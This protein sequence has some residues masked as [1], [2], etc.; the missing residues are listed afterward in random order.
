[1][2][3]KLQVTGEKKKSKKLRYLQFTHTHA[4]PHAQFVTKTVPLYAANY[5]AELKGHRWKGHR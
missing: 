5:T 4:H 1:M 2:N 3:A